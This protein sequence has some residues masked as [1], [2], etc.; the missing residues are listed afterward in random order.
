MYKMQH[1]IFEIQRKHVAEK[2][3][4]SLPL[5]SSIWHLHSSDHCMSKQ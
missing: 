3:K 5:I 1:P 2:N 4:V